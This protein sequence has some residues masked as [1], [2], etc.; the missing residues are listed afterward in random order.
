MI[1]GVGGCW[2][3]DCT[4]VEGCMTDSTAWGKGGEFG[5]GGQQFGPE[6]SVSCCLDAH[7]PSRIRSPPSTCTQ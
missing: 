7:V 1:G 6:H 2:Q 4:R 3:G 5:S